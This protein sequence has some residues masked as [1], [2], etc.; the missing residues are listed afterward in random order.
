MAT[1]RM[2]VTR[3]DWPARGTFR[4]SRSSLSVIPTVQVRIE[5]GER[6]GRAECRPYSRYGQTV[7]SVM[8]ELES[9]R[10]L[11][12]REDDAAYL[13][14]YEALEALPPGPASNA[15]NSAMTD[16]L[17]KRDGRGVLDRLGIKQP[18][19]RETAFTLSVDTPDAMAAAARAASVHTLLKVKLGAENI[20]ASLDA[21]TSARPDASLIVDANEA[22]APDDFATLAPDL[23]R[24]PIVMLEQPVPAGQ[25]QHLPPCPVPI[26]A[27]ESL[28]TKDDIPKLKAAG[29]SAVNVKLDK[30]GGFFA[31]AWLM[32]AARKADMQVMAGCMVGSSL[33]MAPMMMLESLADV[34]DLDGPLLLAED[35]PHGLRY[36]NGLVYPP[37]PELWG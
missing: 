2:T 13:G 18:R 28:H 5:Q 34:I 8:A 4:I 27:D 21:I 23:A 15:L 10:A 22:F 11:V 16:V 1:R 35:E 12:E 25:D 19:P 29:Y 14:F 17:I 26:C 31:A 7:E 20:L 9:V 24:Y 33:A 3:R 6:V 36:E 37:S 30:C 32:K